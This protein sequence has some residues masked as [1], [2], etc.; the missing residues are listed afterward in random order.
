M[1][2]IKTRVRV[3]SG[4]A[5]VRARQLLFSGETAKCLV[6]TLEIVM[7]IISCDLLTDRRTQ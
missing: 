7:S 6:M 1:G 5:H 2:R 3:R 4:S